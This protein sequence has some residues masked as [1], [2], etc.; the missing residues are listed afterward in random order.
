MLHHVKKL[1][2]K[3]FVRDSH[4]ELPLDPDVV[5][6]GAYKWPV[7]FTP[8]FILL[9]FVGGCAGTYAR[10]WVGQ[11]LSSG[12]WPVATVCINL[13]GALLLGLLLEGLARLGHDE[14]SR[15]IARLAVGTGFMGAFTT[16]STFAVETDTLLRHGSYGMAFSYVVITLIGGLAATTIGIQVAA[17][18][19]KRRSRQR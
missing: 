2:K 11:E 1:H 8:S 17:L 10:Y 9:V 18:H 14:G 16:Y 19:H 6:P 5:Q 12:G 3:L 15:R 13:L 7:H 4:P